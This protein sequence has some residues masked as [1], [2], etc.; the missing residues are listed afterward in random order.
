MVFEDWVALLLKSAFLAARRRF[1]L[2]PKAA[3]LPVD[4]LLTEVRKDA[5]QALSMV[6]RFLLYGLRVPGF[7]AAGKVVSSATKP[8]FDILGQQIDP[9]VAPADAYHLD[10][11]LEAA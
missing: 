6:S 1:D 7:N 4:D 8:L 3:E 5:G 11:I 2:D 10:L 9:A